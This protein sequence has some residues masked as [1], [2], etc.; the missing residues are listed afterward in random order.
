MADS[1]KSITPDHVPAEL[2][3]DFSIET[4]PGMESRPF[5]VFRKLQHEAP[6]V[7]YTPSMNVMAGGGGWVVTRMDYVR[8]VFQDY[9]SFPQ[10]GGGDPSADY[11][12]VLVPLQLN[13][14]EH[15]KYRALLAPLFSPKNIDRMD[16]GVR[17]VSAKLIDTIEAG[18]SCEFV[19]AY[20]LPLPTA[21]FMQLMG[22]PLE[23]ADEWVAL[24]RGVIHPV[25]LEARTRE[26]QEADQRLKA[27][28]DAR[29][30]AP[31]DDLVSHILASKIDGEAIDRSKVENMCYLLFMAGLDTVGSTLG[32]MFRYLAEHPE[33]QRQLRADPALIPGAL[34]ELLRCHAIVQTGRT[35]GKDLDF[36]GVKMKKG[37]SIGAWTGVA[38]FDESIFP[39]PDVVDF[40][41]ESNPHISFAAGAHRCAGS[42]L[43]RRELRIALEDWMQRLPEFRI[44]EGTQFQTHPMR[45]ML[46]LDAL[47]IEWGKP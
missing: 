35:L 31:R 32:F 6:P 7:F 10:S 5:E 18:N 1:A 38:N 21:V 8:E 19:Q 9:E 3:Y 15:A 30:K 26:A 13:P 43:A 39:N 12:Q 25:S 16:A 28:I 37:D 23:E 22:L 46:A 17:D 33:A 42:H 20:G 24:N 34:E 27:L 14:P 45:Q 44:P 47:P 4:E 40:T 2:V 41:R 11:P 29:A 36:H